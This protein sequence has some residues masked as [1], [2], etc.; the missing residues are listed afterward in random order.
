MTPDPV[1]RTDVASVLS[2][3][4]FQ[5]LSAAIDETLH[6]PLFVLRLNDVWIKVVNSEWE[7]VTVGHDSLSDCRSILGECSR[8]D[9][10]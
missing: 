6:G 8:S 5:F 9:Q 7:I 4:Y 1:F 10:K 3:R 2:R